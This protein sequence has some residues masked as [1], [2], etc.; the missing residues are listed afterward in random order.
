MSELT[1]FPGTFHKYY[2]GE[3]GP[4]DFE[5]VGDHVMFKGDCRDVMRWMVRD[6]VEDKV[7]LFCTSPPY[8]MSKNYEEGLTERGLESMLQDVADLAYILAKPSGFFFVNFPRCTR[9]FYDCMPEE[10]YARIF[11]RAGWLF[12]SLRI[13]SKPIGTCR[14]PMSGMSL[15]HPIPEGEN[16]F[17]FRKPPNS[18]EE[19]IFRGLSSRG[20]W[21]TPTRGEREEKVARDVHPAMFPIG[22]PIMAIRVWSNKGDIVFDPFGGFFTTILAAHH[23]GRRGMACE[24][25]QEFYYG[26]LQRV[27]NALGQTS[28][29]F[30]EEELLQEVTTELPPDI[31]HNK[32][33]NFTLSFDELDEG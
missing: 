25:I 27:Q 1:P 6:G 17:T 2:D 15:S 19:D 16:L 28:M 12:H 26:G 18:K 30:D 29:A 14:L 9:S 20:I 13:W 10:T 22:L 33:M 5:Q 32:Y 3:P 7:Q 24:R 4:R 31:I 8:A 23:E 21:H 11:E